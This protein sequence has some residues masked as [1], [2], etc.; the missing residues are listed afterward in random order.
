MIDRL[1]AQ[2]GRRLY[3][4]CLVLT[5]NDALAQDLYQD[6]WL[7][8]VRHFDRYDPDK[9]FEPWLTRICVNLYRSGL[10]RLARSPLFDAFATAEEKE[11]TLAAAPAPSRADHS[12]LHAAIDALPQK[13]RLAVVLYYFEDMDIAGAA[14]A[15]GVAPGTVK[16]RL[17]RARA[18]LKEVLTDATDL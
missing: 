13:L 3:G 5:H 1:I 14:A 7:Q 11:A 6:T 2:Y 4:L 17:A 15:L 16:S 18:L 9:P 8:V 10:R 12:D